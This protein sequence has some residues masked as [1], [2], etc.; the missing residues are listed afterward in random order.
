MEEGYRLEDWMDLPEEEDTNVKSPPRVTNIPSASATMT[1]NVE[2]G[3]VSVLKASYLG[4]PIE[5][6]PVMSTSVPSQSTYLLPSSIKSRVI[7][8]DLERISTLFGIPN[9]H[10]MMVANPK[11]QADWRYPS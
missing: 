8:I 11:E 10:K 6:Q 1:I 3:K 2:E 5:P 4:C 7:V 9:E